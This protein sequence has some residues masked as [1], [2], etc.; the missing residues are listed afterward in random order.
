MPK[1]LAG[2][3][4]FFILCV[5][6]LDASVTGSVSGI[7]K[8]PSGA[9]IPNA[10]VSITNSETGIMQTTA[11][12]SSGI[13]SFLALSVG[14]YK[15]SV[16]APG[17]S[18]F[19]QTGVIVNA[20][21]RL[22][23][24]LTLGVAAAESKIDVSGTEIHPETI[25]TQLGDVITGDT[26]TSQPLN[27]RNYTDLLGL[28]PGVNPTNAGTD[29][30]GTSYGA[31]TSTGN[32][33][34]NGMREDANG[35]MVNGGNV[36]EL[37]NNGT[38]ILPNLDSIAEFR[39]LTNSFDAEYGHYNGALVSVV[40]KSGTN[41]WHGDLFEFFRNEALDARNYFDV[42]RGLFRRNQFGGTFGGPIRKDKAFF[43][44]DYQGTRHTQGLSTGLI[45]VP[46]ASERSGTFSDPTSQ[47]TGTVSGP[48]WASILSRRLRYSVAS[49]EAYYAP[50]CTLSSQCVFPN[51]VIPSFAFSPPAKALLQYIPQPN[52]GDFFTSSSNNNGL[53]DDRTGSRVDYKTRWGMLS[54]YYFFSEST[55]KKA[56]GTNTVPGF[57]SEVNTRSQQI[58]VSDT[59]T[60]GTSVV[61]ELRFNL[62]RFSDHND[63]PLAGIG[64]KLSSLGFLGGA[65]GGINA[66]NP[67]LE[68]IPQV[69]FNNF[70]IGPPGLYY[71]RFETSP[72]V[73]DNF[74]KVSGKQTIM[75]GGEFQWSRFI[76]AFPIADSNGLFNFTGSETG[77]DFADF[78]IGA[79]SSF[80]QENPL[81]FDDRKHYI[82]LY[83]QDS[84][85]LRPNLTVNYG[86]RWDLIS[87]WTDPKGD[88]TYSYVNGEQSLVYP[89]APKGFVFAGDP[90][91]GG[92]KIPHSVYPTPKNNFAPRIGLAYSPSV[93]SGPLATILGPP[94][95]FS[96]RTAYGVFYTNNEG[97]Q[98]W[99]IGGGPPFGVFYSSP[100]PPLFEAPYQARADGTIH[101]NPFPFTPPPPG[102]TN[103]TWNAYLPIGGIPA[104]SVNNR[105]P[106][107]EAYH[108]TIQRQFKSNTL[109]SVGY[110]GSQAHALMSATEVNPGS[111]GLCQGLSQPSEVA[112]GTPTCGPFGENGVYTAANGTTVNG[113]RAPFGPD[114]GALVLYST[115]GNSN[116]N[117]LQASLQ[118]SSGR[119]TFLA[120][121]TYA[122][123][124][125]QSSD[126]R[127]TTLNPF[128]PRLSRALSAFDIKH[129]FVISY[130]Y[131][132]PID[133]VQT[134]WPQL[135]KGWIL[136]GITHFATGLPV[137]MVETDDRSLVG[138]F[139]QQLD[140]PN[141]TG[142]HLHFTN[143]RSG[144][145]YF[146]V[147]LFSPE[148]LGQLGNAKRYFFYGPDK[149]NFDLALIKSIHFMDEKD[150][151]FRAEFFNLLNHAQFQNPS[152]NIN[153]GTFG[154]VT[155]AY[156]PR[157]GQLGLKFVF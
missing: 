46:S 135:T 26:M 34:V 148:P 60:H 6:T 149:N 21:D 23:I 145:P 109:L 72:Q 43:F 115:V 139:A 3:F 103:I 48:F 151:E 90:R 39:V 68:G 106:Y 137:Q 77:T 83:A 118:H 128:D 122:K 153:G 123:S 61:N 112:P 22:R 29:D 66:A 70:S 36:E 44:V 62:T 55:L 124:I 113:T 19:E 42:R 114:F 28:Q 95:S 63:K 33:S 87:N 18:H 156:A 16:N 54:A 101:T 53:R 142:G 41:S 131:V 121:Y 58:N 157:I 84:W 126:A 20:N 81:N 32:L 31:S 88:T 37:R 40:T 67:A 50:G 105:T 130:S 71:N 155:A 13:Y 14:T 146:D 64:V 73:I 138:E 117:S 141:F 45:A 116:Y 12:T 102:S 10:T 96:I 97:T 86:V 51:G 152:G 85:R 79:P 147:S 52:Q 125:D 94:G 100:V 129:N 49:G 136:A 57:G 119:L 65:A 82:G 24:D 99:A 17:F 108:L 2:L 47:L 9:V 74:S 89:G 1:P 78:L 25:N 132:L 69:T 27:G 143:P 150:L 98:V 133:K 35:F 144:Q 127:N 15:L 80:A 120:G 75:F 92:G 11:T 30:P 140:A 107:S 76:Q 38:S 59:Y 154:L 8:D 4:I 7:V 111:P 5:G 93:T 110:V 104:W 134:R 56:F 91:P